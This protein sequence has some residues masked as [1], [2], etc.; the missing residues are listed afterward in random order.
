MISVYGSTGFIGSHYCDLYNDNVIRINRN[1]RDPQSKDILYFISTVTNYNVF[2][3]P[4]LDINTNLN[5]LVQTLESCR[6]KYDS[7]FTFNF[8]L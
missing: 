1:T 6:K 8:I 7:D 2:D 5:V 4:H 3:N